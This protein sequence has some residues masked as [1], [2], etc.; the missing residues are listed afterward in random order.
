MIPYAARLITIIVIKKVT[1]KQKTLT[2]V[3]DRHHL[4]FTTRLMKNATTAMV[5][6]QR[7][8][9]IAVPGFIVYFP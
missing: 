4:V 6:I 9:S 1:A 7:P 3:F 8:K 5:S 2:P